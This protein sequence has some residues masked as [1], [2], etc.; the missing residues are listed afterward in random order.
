MLRLF[1]F[2]IYVVFLYY[3]EII[4]ENLILERLRALIITTN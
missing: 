4:E 2:V 3:K 1:Y